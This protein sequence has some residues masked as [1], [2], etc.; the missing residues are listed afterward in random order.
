MPLKISI[1]L[2]VFFAVALAVYFYK[3]IKRVMSDG[4][5][6]YKGSIKQMA[7]KSIANIKNSEIIRLEAVAG[8]VVLVL[9]I[10]TNE[11]MV[12]VIAVPV[13]L[14]LPKFYIKIKR[15]KYIKEYYSGLAGFLESVTSNL[16]AGSSVVKAFQAVA[17][18]DSGPVGV[19]MSIVLKKVELGKSMQDALQE[20]AEKIP[21]KDNEIIVSAVNTALETG[22][23][24][25]E[26]LE[27]ILDT[28]R[29]REELGREVESLTSQGVLSGF[30]VGLLPVFLIAA[31]SAID[32]EFMQPLF[33]T[34][35]GKILLLTAFAMELTGAFAISRI[36]NVK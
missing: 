34:S 12:L 28:I 15:D 3:T 1:S 8:A 31:V 25:T 16:K 27:N 14:Y 30:I 19:E 23:N 20:L 33:A 6:E 29:K 22:G 18:R 32:P 9:F 21:L 26:V 36:I 17:A 35:Q 4:A 11:I 2:L 10:L 7:A 24:I 13:M 5:A